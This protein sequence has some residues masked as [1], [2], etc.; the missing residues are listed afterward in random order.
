MCSFVTFCLHV[1][2]VSKLEILFLISSD[3][4]ILFDN[5]P[6]REFRLEISSFNFS[7]CFSFSGI[8]FLSI[9]ILLSF[10]SFDNLIV[11]SL[12]FLIWVLFF[13]N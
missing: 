8:F 3:V 6:D 7:S 12:K 5:A 10:I 9:T 13:S 11:S 2:Q 4:I 1:G